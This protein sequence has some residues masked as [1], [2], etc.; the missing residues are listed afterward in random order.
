MINHWNNLNVRERWM[1]I[2][3]AVFLLSYLFYLLIYSPLTTAINTHSA[4]LTEKQ[5]TLAW[6]EKIRQQPKNHR[7]PQTISNTKLLA[8]IDSQLTSGVLRQFPYQMQQTSSGE[9]QLSF[10]KVPFS[11]FVF[12]LWTLSRDYALSIK[13]IN[14]EN[15]E[16]PGIVK[17]MIIIATARQDA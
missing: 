15:T 16:T 12:W 1:V 17:L 6:M 3:T 9:I 5:E 4:Q 8:L 7:A 2:I 10:E 13:Q 11:Q 14:T